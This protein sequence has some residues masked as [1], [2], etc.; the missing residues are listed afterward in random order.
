MI[1]LWNQR[2]FWQVNYF[3]R[4]WEWS[5][6]QG[7]GRD[8]ETQNVVS[9]PSRC[10]LLSHSHSD[11]LCTCWNHNQNS[12]WYPNAHSKEFL[13]RST[14]ICHSRSLLYSS[15]NDLFQYRKSRF[16]SSQ[17]ERSTSFHSISLHSITFPK[18]FQFL[19]FQ[20]GKSRMAHE[21]FGFL[22]YIQYSVFSIQFNRLAAISQ[23]L[24]H[25]SLI[26]QYFSLY[27]SLWIHFIS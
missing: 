11:C 12:V 4:I 5:W 15:E 1:L 17:M 26:L 16:D 7:K 24:S 22:R 8:F 14:D 2:S 9:I 19:N 10:K 20:L 6:P 27:R 18:P 3:A 25:L 13:K 21:S 23:D